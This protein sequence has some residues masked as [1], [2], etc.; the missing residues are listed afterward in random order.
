MATLTRLLV[1]IRFTLAEYV[2]SGRFLIELMATVVFWTLFLRQYQVDLQQFFSITGI[3]TLLLTL[4]TTSSLLSL[5]ERPQGYLMLTRP[6]GRNG[7]L[8]GHYVVAVIVVAI[9]FGVVALL[10]RIVAPPFDWSVA[11]LFKGALPLLLNVGLLAALLVLLSS[12][13]LSNTLRLTLLAVLAIALYSNAWHLWPGFRFIEPLQ[14]LFSWPIYPAIAGF[15]LATTREFGSEGP[16]IMLA[17]LALTVLLV[18][19]ALSSFKRRD[20]IL[21]NQ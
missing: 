21:R 10:T 16:Y 9:M 4:Y 12:L 11:E 3:F 6:L 17:Q 18:S 5:G 2:R 8:L 13:V 19:L 1:F 15:R 20:I 7:Y 14:S